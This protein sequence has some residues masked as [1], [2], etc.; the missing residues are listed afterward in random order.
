MSVSHGT[1]R[2]Q[3]LLRAFAEELYNKTKD[4]N[5]K[6]ITPLD[7]SLYVEA[8]V[9]ARQIEAKGIDAVHPDDVSFTFYDLDQ[10]LNELAPEGYYFGAHEGDGSDF[11]YWP[12]DPD[13]E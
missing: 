1:L 4:E 9:L 2:A 8:I 3:D 10:R 7:Y 5:G 11:G 13:D 12:I 6:F